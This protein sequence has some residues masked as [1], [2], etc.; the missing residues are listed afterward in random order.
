LVGGTDEAVV[1]FDDQAARRTAAE[2]VEALTVSS[3][4][5][6]DLISD[7][8][9]WEAVKAAWRQRQQRGTGARRRR[10]SLLEALLHPFEHDLTNLRIDLI[11]EDADGIDREATVEA[12]RAKL[13]LP[14]GWD[15]TYV[16]A[17]PRATPRS[18][19]SAR[20]R[21]T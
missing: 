4:P 12:R 6:A 8:V 19:S 1:F 10:P 20:L 11:D 3:T 17:P 2:W 9:R 16:D 21:M 7:T 14:P 13:P 18:V 5:L 15:Y